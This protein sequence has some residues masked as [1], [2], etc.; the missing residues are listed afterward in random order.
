MW[1]GFWWLN[2]GPVTGSC[3]CGQNTGVVDDWRN[4]TCGE[5]V[6]FVLQLL[7]DEQKQQCV[8]VC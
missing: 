3:E 5:S 6:K 4:W 1:T 7:I 8:F 2:M